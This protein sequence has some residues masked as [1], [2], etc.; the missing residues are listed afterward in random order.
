MEEFDKTE[1][2]EAEKKEIEI[3]DSVAD[4]DLPPPMMENDDVQ[5]ELNAEEVHRKEDTTEEDT[6]EEDIQLIAEKIGKT[7]EQAKEALEKANGDVAE[8]ILELS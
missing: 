4:E 1:Y 8:A 2:S 3:T 6:T 5:E 7:Q